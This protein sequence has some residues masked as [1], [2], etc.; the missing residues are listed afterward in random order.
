MIATP[1]AQS[2]AICKILGILHFLDSEISGFEI[3]SGILP[4]LGETAIAYQKAIKQTAP[5]PTRIYSV[6]LSSLSAEIE[7]LRPVIL[8]LGALYA[9]LKSG[10]CIKLRKTVPAKHGVREE[11]FDV[12]LQR[13]GLSEFWPTTGRSANVLGFG[14]ALR[15]IQIL[16][17]L[18]IQAYTG[19][20][21]DE[22]SHLPYFCV[23]ET[24]RNRDPRIHYIVSGTTTKLNA[25]KEQ[26][27]QWIT[28][29][30]AAKA[31][32]IAQHLAKAIYTAEGVKINR[33]NSRKNG[34][35]LFPRPNCD[36]K[37]RA[38]G[39]LQARP[40]NLKNT[41]RIDSI[42]AP[43]IQEEDQQELYAI[44]SQ[45]SWS[46]ESRYAVGSG[47]HLT[48]HQ[49]RRS[50]ALYAQS[51]GLV[52]LPTLKRQLQHITIEMSLYYA[53]GSAFSQNFIGEKQ[54][55][56][57]KHFGSDWQDAQPVSQFLAYAASILLIDESDIF[58]GHG[59]WLKTRK[60]DEKG[61]IILNRSET[62]KSFQ[63]GEMAYRPT[64]LGG[65][66]SPVSCDKPPI[67]I[68]SVECIRADCKNLIASV[69]KVKRIILVKKSTIRKL[70][71]FDPLS[72][73]IRI[74]EAEL[75][76]LE[77]GL[78]RAEKLN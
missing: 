38:P 46:T 66:V 11:S 74:E 2:P 64:P 35:F 19:M 5:I 3:A 58:G 49:L 27:T 17:S 12:L 18:Q 29:E 73:E 4:F 44:D 69:E 75:S 70:K 41:A 77:A 1:E 31:I 21:A 43:L 33:L 68:L 51:S 15:E 47:W 9:E 61:Q 24:K 62:M 37:P 30:A 16:I 56:A 54:S 63:K 67:N 7:K 48:S 42:L 39:F 76:V 6:I 52:S 20:R 10:Q 59:Q 22:V 65:C 28:I 32:E 53:K 57:D 71:E 14:L 45:R 60:R 78:A 36:G 23:E 50:L 8:N 72:A 13:F 25:G 55:H 26:K 34:S 40:A